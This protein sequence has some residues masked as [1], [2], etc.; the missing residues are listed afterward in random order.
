M[1]F[2]FPESVEA[3]R[4]VVKKCKKGTESILLLSVLFFI[5]K[6]FVR[7]CEDV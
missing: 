3:A 6:G 5:E 2:R 4:D 1:P 7:M